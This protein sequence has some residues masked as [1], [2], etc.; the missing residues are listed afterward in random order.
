MK[1]KIVIIGATSAIAEECAREWLRKDQ[2]SELVMVARNAEKCSRI[3]NDLQIRYPQTTITVIAATNFLDTSLINN[4]VEQT[5]ASKIPDIIL[6][7]HGSLPEQKHC[8]TDIKLVSEAIE[9]NGLSP[10]LFAEAYAR[11]LEIAGRG[12]LAVIGSVAGDR[13]RKSN[14]V[15]GA[16]KG[17]V[18]RYMQGLQ[19]RFA[20][21][22][23]QITLI[24]PGPTDTPMT[25][26]LK[27]HGAKLA[28]VNI[29]AKN[30]TDG[31]SKG[32]KVIYTPTKWGLIMAIIRHLPSFIFNK[33][34]I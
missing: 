15:Y 34:D 31:I 1:K 21:T 30:I 10:I 27:Q 26:T 29:V 5:C 3:G 7:A 20:N 14:Y 16:A 11:K 19:H 4:L 18:S 33:L 2:T 24:K 8:E 17:L 12:I 25:N 23:I 28:D 6:I 32:K 13:G 22:A 9:I